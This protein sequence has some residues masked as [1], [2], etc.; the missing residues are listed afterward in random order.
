VHLDGSTRTEVKKRSKREGIAEV[1]RRVLPTGTVIL[2]IALIAASV[3]AVVFATIRLFSWPPTL[4][5]LLN[6]DRRLVLAG[7]VVAG[8]TLLIALVAGFVA[9]AA[10][11][12]SVRAP[13]LELYF[14]WGPS[15][16]KDVSVEL[17]R[18]H[19][20]EP[21]YQVQP[22]YRYPVLFLKNPTRNTAR[23]AALRLRFYGF[24]GDLVERE[25][26]GARHWRTV[27]HP[28]GGEALEWDGDG[29]ASIHGT[30][31]LALPALDLR[32]IELRTSGVEIAWEV[33]AEQFAESGLTTVRCQLVGTQS[34]EL[35]SSPERPPKPPEI[36]ASAPAPVSGGAA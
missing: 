23:N 27:E 11:L 4:T 28:E 30:W 16:A 3:A 26:R 12:V 10:Y 8:A 17:D 18:S 21:F 5:E 32:Q 19:G 9:I 25:S 2:A 14:Q 15:K 33:V 13:Q 6:D 1:V 7:D 34:V 35:V 22:R 29:Q 24:R 36:V 31:Q 20:A